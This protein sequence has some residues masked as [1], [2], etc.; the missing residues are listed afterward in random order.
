MDTWSLVLVISALAG[1][2]VQPLTTITMQNKD[3]CLAALQTI[4]TESAR[5]IGGFCVDQ[6]TGEVVALPAAP[7]ARSGRRRR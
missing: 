2:R 5:A 1:G 3:A 7:R 4:N 6:K